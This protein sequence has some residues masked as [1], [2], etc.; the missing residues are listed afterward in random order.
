MGGMSLFADKLMHEL[1]FRAET[2]P[3]DGLAVRAAVF[4]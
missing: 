3:A 1:R 4:A 2:S